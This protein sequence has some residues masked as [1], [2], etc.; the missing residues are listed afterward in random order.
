MKNST[1]E[2]GFWRRLGAYAVDWVVLR[3]ICA[4]LNFL[5]F[6]HTDF[7]NWASEEETGP[8]FYVFLLIGGII[9]LYWTLFEASK[10]QATPGKLALGIRVTDFDGRRATFGKAALRNLA[11]FLSLLPFGAGFLMIAITSKK[12]GLHD[13][14]AGTLVLRKKAS[15]GS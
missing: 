9:W 12:Q 7:F 5:L 6:M 2:A 13:L 4:P 10:L 1:L 15:E 14:L 8:P 3:L 11:K